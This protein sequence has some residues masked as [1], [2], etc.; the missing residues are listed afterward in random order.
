VTSL[1][2]LKPLQT[3]ITGSPGAYAGTESTSSSSFE[4]L[5]AGLG[6]FRYVAGVPHVLDR[7]G[8]DLGQVI[9]V[10]TLVFCAFG[11]LSLTGRRIEKQ[12]ALVAPLGLMLI[13]WGVHEYPLLGRTQLFL[14]PSYV[15]LLAEGI[16]SSILRWR[17]RSMRAGF[18]AGAGVVAIALAAPAFGHI[19]H[20]RR[21]EDMKPV[22]NYL[23]RHQLPTDTVYVYY[24]AQYQLRY[25]MQCG[26]AGGAFKKA[27]RAGLWPMRPSPGGPAEFA[28]TL[29]SV[30]PRLIVA[31]YR[32]RDPQPY[33]A[34]FD[35]LRGRARVWVL[36]SRTI[37]AYSCFGN[38][39]TVEPCGLLSASE[40]GR[41][42]S[43]HISM[44]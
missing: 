40:A 3:A 15:L 39:T 1:H 37:D 18:A 27:R 2:D 42:Q 30:P 8:F 36:L 19:V 21:F 7:G 31:P 26:C 25:Y 5:K 23:A 29:K 43:A 41:T 34:D 38:S 20:P 4:S 44:T 6:E 12:I 17:S 14:V 32:G 11:L 9:F 10:L 13:A 22:L 35:S 33:V 28:P 24:T 16:T